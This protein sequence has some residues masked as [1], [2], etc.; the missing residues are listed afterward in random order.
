M[1]TFMKI[2][3][4]QVPTI[5][6]SMFLSSV[7]YT[8]FHAFENIENSPFMYRLM[9]TCL[10]TNFMTASLITGNHTSFTRYTGFIWVLSLLSFYGTVTTILFHPH[11]EYM[12][13]DQMF[14]NIHVFYIWTITAFINGFVFNFSTETTSRLIKLYKNGDNNDDDDDEVKKNNRTSK[15]KHI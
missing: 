10:V 15:R 7:Y 8:A 11:F 14:E 1:N 6:S 2:A 3:E 13:Q 9:Q 5:F 12:R 4:T